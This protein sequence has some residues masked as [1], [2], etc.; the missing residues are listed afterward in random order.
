MRRRGAFLEFPRQ[1]L[2]ESVIDRIA[3]EGYDDVCLYVIPDRDNMGNAIEQGFTIEQGRKLHDWCAAR[4]LG[5]IVF[6]GYMKYEEPLLAKEPHRAMVTFGSKEKLDSDGA[7]SQWLCPFQPANRQRYW[8]SVIS[9]VLQWSALRQI[10]LNDEAFLG[11]P[12]GAIGCYC[13]YCQEA[14][15]KVAGVKPPRRPDDELLWHKWMSWRGE[16]WT[17]FHAGLR[18]SVHKS[19]PDVFVGIQH[20]PCAPLFQWNN[21]VSAIDLGRDAVALDALCTDPYHFLHLSVATLRPHRRLL[22][23]ATRSLVGACGEDRKTGICCQGFMPPATSTPIDRTDGL[24]AATVPFA[25]G[26]NLAFPYTNEL[27]RIVA[28]FDEGWRDGARLLPWFRETTP[29]P[30]AVVLAPMKT[31]AYAH[32]HSN[33]AAETLVPLMDVMHRVGLPW[34]WIFDERLDSSRAWPRANGPVVLPGATAL[35][36]LQ[37]ERIE[38]HR[39]QGVLYIGA[40]A[41]GAWSGNGSCR[42]AASGAGPAEL[43]LNSKATSFWNCP[44]PLFLSSA[45]DMPA[46]VKGEVIGTIDGKPGLVIN[47]DSD[48]RSAWIAGSPVLHVPTAGMHAA[49]VRPSAS[50]ELLRQLLLWLAP[51]PPYACFDPQPTTDYSRLRPWDVR[52]INTA[53]L[54]PMLG[55]RGLFMLVFPYLPLGF[56]AGVRFR[57]PASHRM[58][59]V[60]DVWGNDDVTNRVERLPD[61]SL[62]LP[63]RFDAVQDLMALWV[64][65]E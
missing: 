38:M 19:R 29:A 8:D 43:K 2:S 36:P 22:T 5:V 15:R 60:V 54:F 17:E 9:P 63:I 28:G 58:K 42:A 23:E 18:D 51:E 25:L 56:D 16:R 55:E 49:V 10:D 47:N 33:W 34:E 30:F 50:I 35:T 59:S 62:R 39:R 24:L 65:F 27:S 31:E 37:I 6:S 57:L 13:D 45:C 26:A 3:S 12:S 53:E 41:D 61:G 64:R 21:G 11:F 52:G 32:P 7:A 1:S 44:E 48:G 4:G 20:S 46:C 14:F 40:V